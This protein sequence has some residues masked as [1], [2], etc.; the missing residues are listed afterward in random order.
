M[1]RIGRIVLPNYPHHVVQRGHNRQVV[2]AEAEDY[3]RYLSTLREFIE[4]YGVLVYAFCL[5]TNHVHL[6]LAP[7]DSSGIGQLIKTGRTPNSPS[8]PARRPKRFSLGR[9]LQVERGRV[10][11]VSP[12]LLSLH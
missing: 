2:F 1:P 12:C 7:H 6:L 9:A 10:R 5:M 8:Q 3:Q 4:E 11:H